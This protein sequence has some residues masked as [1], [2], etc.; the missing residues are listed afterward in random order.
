M[1]Y[2]AIVT[3][4]DGL[5]S[6][7]NAVPFNTAILDLT[8]NIVTGVFQDTLVVGT[9]LVNITLSEFLNAIEPKV[10]TDAGNIGVTLTGSDI[11]YVPLVQSKAAMLS[12]ANSGA[13]SF[14]NNASR[15][16]VTTAAAANGFQ[17]SSSRD[18]T[19][20]YGVQISTTATI[21]GAASGYVVLEI[22]TTNSTT[23][24]DWKEISRVT[25]SQ[26]ISLAIVLQS[27]Q[28]SG[29]ALQGMVPAGYYARLRTVTVSGSPVYQFNSGQEV[30]L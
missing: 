18:S 5:G 19:V 21:G 2:K 29:G 12:I 3:G 10:I 7:G 15:S 14:T 26:T 24:A 9:D 28:I 22:A 17:L 4:I 1:A 11:L 25:N 8:N 16:F 30:L 27:V 13:K 6:G 23:A 20:S